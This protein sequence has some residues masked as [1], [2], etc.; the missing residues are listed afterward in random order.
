MILA[1]DLPLPR[2]RAGRL[3]F[4]FAGAGSGRP[5]VAQELAA[6]QFLLMA[7]LSY[8]QTTNS[9]SLRTVNGWFNTHPSAFNDTVSVIET[10]AMSQAQYDAFNGSNIS[11]VT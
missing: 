5:L 2:F 4:R 6:D 8:R 10:V 11:F 1:V 9:M 3:Q 7:L